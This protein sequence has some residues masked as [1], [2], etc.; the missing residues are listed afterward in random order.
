MSFALADKWAWDFW[1]A[2]D[3]GNYHLFFLQADKSL[4]DP[5]LRHWNVS[6]GHAV[7]T[8]LR[9]WKALG[10][11]LAPA[12]GPAFDDGTTWTGSIIRHDGLWHLFYTGT[13][14][15]EDRKKQRIGLA[16]ST[17]LHRW[18]RH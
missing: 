7:S 1:L 15:S 12:R 11:C 6:I 9:S 17:D 3:G 13:S 8:D 4:G 14:T 2:Q 16:T 10:T 5:D 18:Q